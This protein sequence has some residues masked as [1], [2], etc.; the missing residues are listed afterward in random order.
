MPRS[1]VIGGTLFIGR[2]LSDDVA[3]AAIL[4]AEKEG[5]H[6][7]GESKEWF[8]DRIFALVHRDTASN[9]AADVRQS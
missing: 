5:S 6:T 7:R 2:A 4:A 1:L 8:C 3:R 9:H